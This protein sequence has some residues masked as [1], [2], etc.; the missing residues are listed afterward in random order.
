MATCLNGDLPAEGDLGTAVAPLNSYGS[1]RAEGVRR[2]NGGS[3]LLDPDSLGSQL[4]PK[5]GEELIFKGGQPV[6]CGKDL[7]F[8]LLQFLGDVAL[9]VGKGLLAD[10]VR[11]YLIHKG[12]GNFDIIAEDTVKSD[13]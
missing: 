3:G 7:I 5:L 4:L 10:L 9:A 6:L 1:E 12:L 11:R 2:G 13:F 8:Q